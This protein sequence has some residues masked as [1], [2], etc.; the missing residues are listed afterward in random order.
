MPGSDLRTRVVDAALKLLAKKGWTD[1]MLAE[2][3]RAAKVPIASLQPIAPNKPV[4]LGLILMRLAAEAGKRHK[5]DGKNEDVRDRLLDICLTLFEAMDPR[6]SAVR[7]L[8]EGLRRDPLALV[9]ARADIARAASW[10]L[11][12][13]EADTGSTVQIRALALAGIV[14]RAIPV[15]LEDDRQMSKTMAKLDGDLRRS[16]MLFERHARED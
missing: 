7:S 15:W 4:L 13:A 9:A 8:Y 10:L 6:K 2:V 12:L 3:A 5:Q 1:L 11:A 16:S 14:A